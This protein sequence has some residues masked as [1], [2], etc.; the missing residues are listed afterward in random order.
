[1]KTEVPPDDVRA[2]PMIA[3]IGAPFSGKTTLARH[4][5]SELKTA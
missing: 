5:E 2:T 4:L 3:V 1:M